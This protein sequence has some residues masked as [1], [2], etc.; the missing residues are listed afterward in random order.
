MLAMGRVKFKVCSYY[1][2]KKNLCTQTLSTSE[3]YECS[4]FNAAFHCQ[5]TTNL[6]DGA[7]ETNLFTSGKWPNEKLLPVLNSNVSNECKFEI[8]FW[9]LVRN[10]E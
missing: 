4:F 1:P 5:G 7:M 10:N 9:K 6:L 2:I 3:M 8:P